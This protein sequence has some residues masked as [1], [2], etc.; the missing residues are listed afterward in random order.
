MQTSMKICNCEFLHVPTTNASK[1][2]SNAKYFS[3]SMSIFDASKTLYHKLYVIIM[4]ERRNA[5]SNNVDIRYV[6]HCIMFP[7]KSVMKVGVNATFI[8]GW[9]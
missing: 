1:C 6:C 3:C 9:R 4:E 8:T 7:Q 5:K 2:Q